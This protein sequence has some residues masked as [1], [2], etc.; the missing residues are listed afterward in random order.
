MSATRLDPEACA[1]C[2]EPTAAGRPLF[3]GRR[4]I[5]DEGGSRSLLCAGCDARITASRRGRP[6]TDEEARRFINNGSMAAIHWNGGIGGG[7][8]P[9]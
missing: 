6:L 8:G 4:V 1:S 5:T 9:F 3:P 7:I 2:D